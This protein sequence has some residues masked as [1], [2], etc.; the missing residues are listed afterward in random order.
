MAYGEVWPDAR[1]HNKR[2]RRLWKRVFP[3]T[4]FGR[5][6]TRGPGQVR[7][8]LAARKGSLAADVEFQYRADSG[9]IGGGYIESKLSALKGR[10]SK[11]SRYRPLGC[12]EFESFAHIGDFRG[13]AAQKLRE[14]LRWQWSLE[15]EAL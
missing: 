15:V 13:L 7:N 4:I 10:P 14:I 2:A 11:C 6:L 8:C 3:N 9:V 5:W 1:Y 12:A